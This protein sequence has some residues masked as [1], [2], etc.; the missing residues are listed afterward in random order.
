M[1]CTVTQLAQRLGA[2][3]IGDGDRT[4]TGCAPIV[5][6][7]PDQITFLANPRYRRHLETTKAAAVII[8]E[9][10]DCPERLTRLVSDDPYFAFRNAMIELHGFRDHPKPMD[11]EQPDERGRFISPRANIHPDADI[12]T[13]AVIHPNVTVEAGAS[14]GERTAL[15]P[16]VYIGPDSAIG[17]DCLIYANVTIY[18]H[19]RIGDRVT[20]HAST[21]IGQDGFGYAT[22]D[23]AHH[24]IPQRGIVVIGDD[25][26]L[27]AGCA[28][29]RAAME[30][31]R[32]GAGTKFADLISIGHGTTIGAHCLFVS[33]VGVSGSVDVGDY[34]VLGGQVG[35]AGHLTIGT[36]VQAAGRCAIASDIAPG[37]KVGGEPAVEIDRAKRNILAGQNLYEMATRLRKL[38]RR[39]NRFLD[40]LDQPRSDEA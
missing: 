17:E 39:F 3:L 15:Y 19:C 2:D 29:E 10:I 38:E 34:V 22:H 9:G 30:E 20:L 1:P 21:V 5:T 40:A 31:T 14:V 13:G 36:G 37:S 33:L 28:I 8:A 32:I 11:A 25:V 26:E 35:V 12:G 27:G 18:D 6:A 4:V 7:G 16:G 23:E 24:K